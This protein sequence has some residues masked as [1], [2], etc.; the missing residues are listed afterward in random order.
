MVDKGVLVLDLFSDIT[1]GGL[2]MVLSVGLKVKCYTSVEIDECSR[3]I[4]NEV[5][6]K[7]QYEYPHQLP[8]SALLG[9]NKRLPNDFRLITDGDVK[10]LIQNKR[11]VHFICGSWQCQSMAGPKTGREDDR[12]KPFLDMIRIV[13][14]LQRVQCMPPIYCFENTWP[15][16][17][18]K[19]KMVDETTDMIQA[20]LGAPVIVDAAGIG[21]ASHRLRYYWKNLCELNLLENAMPR[22][23]MPLPTLNDILDP[24]HTTSNPLVASR[25]PFVDHNKVGY[26]RVCLPNIMSYPKSFAYRRRVN[27][28][29]GGGQ[30]WDR[31]SQGWIEPSI[32]EKEQL[33]GYRI[34]DSMG[35]HAIY[36]ETYVRTDADVRNRALANCSNFCNRK[37]L[38]DG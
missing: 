31:V 2:R 13:N 11:E 4:T 29:P 16:P 30:L 17:K 27:G 5:L 35:G 23:I 22:D 26:E 6:S 12:F 37:N 34:D 10:A 36:P 15:G 21:S 14:T 3:G 19:N 33:L 24:N 32:H 28:N 7:L 9:N 18:G 38:R 8:D 1:C 20:F 25:W